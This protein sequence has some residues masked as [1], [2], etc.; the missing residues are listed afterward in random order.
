[1]D[2]SDKD[3]ESKRKIQKIEVSTTASQPQSS[4]TNPNFAYHFSWQT[5]L[6]KDLEEERKTNA[7]IRASQTKTLKDN[8]LLSKEKDAL[9]LKIKHLED[10]L[11]KSDD[12]FP[13]KK[14]NEE[15][16]AE[17]QRLRVELGKLSCLEVPMEVEAIMV[18]PNV[19]QLRR[20]SSVSAQAQDKKQ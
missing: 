11:S 12:F 8:L 2:N 6:Q 15:L 1:M 19:Y 9:K 13:L 20:V 16:L 14:K 5:S 10:K 7:E 3:T 4:E 18:R 17:N